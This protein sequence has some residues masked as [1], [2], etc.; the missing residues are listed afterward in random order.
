MAVRASDLQDAYSEARRRSC[1]TNA[2]EQSFPITLLI[3][4]DEVRCKVN[5]HAELSYA[6]K[7]LQDR[8]NKQ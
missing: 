8:R 5:P 6:Q 1:A 4:W 7:L 3:E 2:S